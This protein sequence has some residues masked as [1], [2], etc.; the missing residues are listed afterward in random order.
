VYGDDFEARVAGLDRITRDASV[1][2]GLPCIRGT[3]FPVWSVLDW[4]ASGRSPEQLAAEFPFLDVEAVRQA[5]KWSAERLR[6]D[7][8]VPPAP[9][10]SRGEMSAAPD[11]APVAAARR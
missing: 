11:E 10:V 5:L 6:T 1:Q 4:F 3:R 8:V 7:V 9:T 2:S